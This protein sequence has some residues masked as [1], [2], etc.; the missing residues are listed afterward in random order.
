MKKQYIILNRVSWL[1]D[2]FDNFKFRRG[3]YKGLSLLFYID[4]LMTRVNN[5]I[6]N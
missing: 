2:I 1:F 5:D 6:I 4:L 3:N